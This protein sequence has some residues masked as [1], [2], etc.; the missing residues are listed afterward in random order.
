VRME[1]CR[2]AV[3]SLSRPRVANLDQV[4]TVRGL[5]PVCTEFFSTIFGSAF[6]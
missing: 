6:F 4:C 1:L 2:R 5:Q 3:G